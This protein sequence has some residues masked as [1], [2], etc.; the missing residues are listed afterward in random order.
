[1]VQLA[2]DKK[3]LILGFSVIGHKTLAELQSRDVPGLQIDGFA[4][5]GHHFTHVPEYL[6][7]VL[8]RAAYDV[9]VLDLVSSGCRPWAKAESF[10]AHLRTILHKIGAH[11]ARA[12]FLHFWRPE[13]DASD[14]ML[15]QVCARHATAHNIPVLDFAVGHVPAIPDRMEEFFVSRFHLTIPGA[16]WTCDIMQRDLLPPEV[17]ETDQD[18]VSIM[19]DPA[20]MRRCTL[21]ADDL[22]VSARREQFSRGG[23]LANLAVHD[24]GEAVIL[25]LPEWFWGSHLYFVAGPRS[26][27]VRVTVAGEAP[28]LLNLYDKKCYY[29]RIRTHSVKIGKAR[30]IRLKQMPGR[31]DVKLSKGEVDDG[32]RLLKWAWFGGSRME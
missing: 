15:R 3:V 13:V 18:L 23:V 27:R 32:P 30:Q 22:G 16:V 21:D 17:W 2:N 6:D 1:M 25:R 10:D 19:P 20:L 12:A 4:L 7:R 11:G 24:E 5:G 26:G 31:P 14:D 9:V 28:V 29:D 8:G